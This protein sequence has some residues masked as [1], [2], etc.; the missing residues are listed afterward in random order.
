MREPRLWTRLAPIS[1][2]QSDEDNRQ[3]ICEVVWSAGADVERVDWTGERWL[4]R[5][6][7]SPN[8]VDLSRLVG[9]PVLRSHRRE[10]ED[11]V[12]VVESASIEDGVG[13]ARI[14]FSRRADVDPIVQDVADRVL[15]QVSVGYRVEKWER[16]QERGREVRIARRWQ[17]LEVSLVAVGAD[18]AARVR[19]EEVMGMDTQTTVEVRGGPPPQATPPAPDPVAL[20]RQRI[21]AID[22]VLSD[23]RARAQLPDAVIDGLRRRAIVEGLSE[24]QVRSAL[25]DAVLETSAR[26]AAKPPVVAYGEVRQLGPSGDDPEEIM[27]AMSAALAIRSLPTQMAQMVASKAPER[28]REYVSLRPSDMLIELALARGERVSLRDRMSLIERGAHTSGDFP[29]LLQ[30]SGQT[31]LLA[32]YQNIT[33]PHRLYWVEKVFTDFRDHEFVPDTNFPVLKELLPG[34][35]IEL[36][37]VGEKGEKVRARTYARGFRITR[38]ALINDQLGA[39][40]DWAAKVARAVAASEAKVAADLMGQNSG[41]GPLLAEGNARVFT[42]TRGNKASTGSAITIASLGAAREAIR[43]QTDVDGNPIAWN[44]SWTLVVGPNKETEAE[45]LIIPFAPNEV[46]RNNPFQRVTNIVVDSAIPSTRWYLFAGGM[47]PYVYGYI[48]NYREPTMNVYPQIAGQ[49]G[50]QVDVVHYFGVGAID[51]RGGYFNPGA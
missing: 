12:G 30:G 35:E 38:E 18:P 48:T 5:L 13:T 6:D 25:L 7:M 47:C 29:K 46:V 37:T 4:E 51:W 17:P 2:A 43:K 31:V 20:E 1:P 41:E 9:G 21:A 16:V 19:E 11:V 32:A 40:V 10:L 28:F 44:N 22:D 8:A 34:G 14:R 36:G 33:P 27:A 50:M 39:F 49:D 26:A 23:V 3:R 45:Q 24:Q 15:T 42:T